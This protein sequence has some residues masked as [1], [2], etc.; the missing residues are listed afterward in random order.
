MDDASCSSLG[1]GISSMFFL[2]VLHDPSWPG[3]NLAKHQTTKTSAMCWPILSSNRSTRVLKALSWADV[4]ECCFWRAWTA[5]STVDNLRTSWLGTE[6]FASAG[7]GRISFN[8]LP[9]KVGEV[10][11]S[12]WTMPHIPLL[13]GTLQSGFA[14]MFE[15]SV[16]QFSSWLCYMI[17]AGQCKSVRFWM[18]NCIQ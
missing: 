9:A 5:D 17:P 11:V 7:L 4:L 18:A 3:L 16:A 15:W 6:H 10:S 8:L 13:A 1:R 2:I 12:K 14:E